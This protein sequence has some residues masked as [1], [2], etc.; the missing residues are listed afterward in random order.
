MEAEKHTL[1]TAT[2]VP[3]GG[4]PQGREP[5]GREGPLGPRRPRAGGSWGVFVVE[6]AHSRI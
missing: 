4:L 5:P 6:G 2:A 1:L 3:A